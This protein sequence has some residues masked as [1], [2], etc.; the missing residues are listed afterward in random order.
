MSV[1]LE[2]FGS[3]RRRIEAGQKFKQRRLSE[4]VVADEKDD[5]GPCGSLSVLL[6][7][8]GVHLQ[9][10]IHGPAI[11]LPPMTAS[12]G[13]ERMTGLAKTACEPCGNLHYEFRFQ[14]G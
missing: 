2:D 12:G 3:R 1:I 6:P 5:P 7:M 4:A 9:R 10:R 13:S 8:R 14:I 11:G